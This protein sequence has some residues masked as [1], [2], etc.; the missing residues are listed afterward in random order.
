MRGFTL[1]EILVVLVIVAVLMMVALP[2]YQQQLIKTRR[3]I[4]RGELQSLLARQEQ[5]FVDHKSYAKSLTSL[6]FGAS[7]YAINEAGDEVAATSP[8][9]T[10]Q[11]SLASTSTIA[12]LLAAEPQLRQANDQLCAKL[13]IDST[14]VKTVGGTG[15]LS[16]CW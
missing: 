3:T 12:F 2:T 13:T 4:A 9:R 5:F 14:G 16:D 10:Y 6:G 8:K 15:S 7:P 11:I 1:I